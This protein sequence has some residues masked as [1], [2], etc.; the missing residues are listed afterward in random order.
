MK[1]IVL[2]SGGLDSTVCVAKALERVGNE[3]VITVSFDYG[4]KHSK[5]LQCA[6]KVAQHYGLKHYIL[7]IK[8][9]LKYSNCSLLKNSSQE[10][11]HESYAEQIEKNG[12]GMVST[13]VPFRNGLML[14]AV[15]SLAQSLFLEEQVLIYYGA[16]ADDAAGC[17]YADC[18]QE[19]VNAI[20]KAIQIGTYNLVS[21]E[22]PLV[23]LT[24]AQV[25]KEGIRLNVPFELTWS[26]YEGGEKACG[27]CG[28]CIDRLAAFAANNIKDPISY[29]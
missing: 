14:S 28:T 19:F 15:A 27:T 7:Q 5:E 4:Q 1:I 12:E 23:T 10:I 16:H 24:K 29:I 6:D 26:C 17:A 21:L 3:N 13:Y 8:D 25:V 20:N 22:G 18:S 9:I 2:S 11:I